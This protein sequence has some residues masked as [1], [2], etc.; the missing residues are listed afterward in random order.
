MT[1]EVAKNKLLE[2]QIQELQAQI[3]KKV[4]IPNDLVQHSKAVHE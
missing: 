3:V 2:E 4:G 1:E